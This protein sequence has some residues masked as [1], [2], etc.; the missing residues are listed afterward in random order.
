MCDTEQ[1]VVAQ[2]GNC[3]SQFCSLNN[4][5]PSGEE[6]LLMKF[7]AMTW[8]KISSFAKDG[9][10]ISVMLTETRRLSLHPHLSCRWVNLEQGD[11]T[12]ALKGK[13][14]LI[15]PFHARRAALSETSSTCNA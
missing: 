14:R 13:P 8:F 6:S 5:S 1:E 10:E 3:L 4:A 12:P 15:M 2:A 11:L 7:W 9:T